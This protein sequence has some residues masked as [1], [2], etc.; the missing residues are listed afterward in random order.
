M[1]SQVA[2]IRFGDQFPQAWRISSVELNQV[3]LVIGLPDRSG[4]LEGQTKKGSENHLIRKGM[5]NN[6]NR[7]RTVLTPDGSESGANTL[8]ELVQRLSSIK[9]ILGIATSL[10]PFFLGHRITS[11]HLCPLELPMISLV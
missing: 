9:L 11:I 7:S 10:P 4:L 3:K 5:A 6:E 2:E 1:F 8:I